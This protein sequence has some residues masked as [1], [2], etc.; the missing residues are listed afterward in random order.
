ME[1]RRIVMADGTELIDSTIG[2]S[3]GH[4]WCFLVNI[5]FSTAYELFSDA[6][7]TGTLIF[8]YGDMQDVYEGYTKVH[9]VKT[10]EFGVDVR[11]NKEVNN[12]DS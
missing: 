12:A 11:L 7:K 10:T 8:D 5:S 2:Y 1:G 4:I 9:T 6:Q 3:D